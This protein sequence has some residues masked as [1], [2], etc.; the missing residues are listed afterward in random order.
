MKSIDK[1]A[2][3]SHTENQLEQAMVSLIKNTQVSENHLVDNMGLFLNSRLMGRLLFMHEMYKKILNVHGIVIEF[4]TRFGQNLSLFHAFRSLY[5]PYNRI[6]K[7]IAF[8]TF[9]GF[10]NLTPQDGQSELMQPGFATTS[11]HYELYLEEVMRVKELENPMSHIKKFD[12]IKGDAIQTVPQYLRDYPETIIALAYFDFDL[13]TPTKVCLEAIRPH[14]VKGSVIGFDELGDHDAPGETMAL[15]ETFG[16]YNVRLQRFPNV[17]RTS[18]F[19]V[20]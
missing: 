6:R 3:R 9:A 14:L 15:N 20:E 16:L 11:E 4:G 13:Y 10:P 19:V 8:D 1:I 2:N 17:S 7:I 5:E 18:Y 12:L